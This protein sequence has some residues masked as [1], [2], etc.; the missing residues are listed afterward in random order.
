MKLNFYL[1]LFH[2]FEIE[3]EIPITCNPFEIEILG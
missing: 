3:V 1:N 2:E